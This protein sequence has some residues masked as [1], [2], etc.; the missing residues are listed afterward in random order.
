MPTISITEGNL[1]KALGDFL[2]SIVGD[3]VVKGQVNR[4][5][6]PA[7]DTV[8]MTPGA[9]VQLATVVQTY[10]DEGTTHTSNFKQSKQ[11]AAQIDCYGA[12]ANDCAAAISTALRT[13]Y[14]C[15]FF[16]ATGLEIQPLYATD[17]QQLPLVTGENQYLERWGLQA[18]LQY[19]PVITV[20]Q[21]FA[22]Q[23]VI[24]LINVDAT[25][26]AGA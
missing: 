19:N 14:A 21:E 17:P 2:T 10:T 4:V 12:S 24:G 6:M 26:P 15:D 25:F 5:P 1:F 11:W 3:I 20:T 7:G 13:I 9:S 8:Y 18:V 23:L 22:D 16:K